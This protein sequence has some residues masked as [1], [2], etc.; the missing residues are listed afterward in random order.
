[1]EDLPYLVSTYFKVLTQ[2]QIMKKKNRRPRNS[3]IP[4]QRLDVDQ[5]GA[6][7]DCGNMD[8]SM[9]SAWRIGIQMLWFG[10][11]LFPKGSHAKAWSLA[12]GTV[13]GRW[14]KFEEMWLSGGSWSLRDALEC[15]WD[16]QVCMYLSLSLSL[17]LL[18]GHHEV[19]H[20]PLSCTP[21][22]MMY[23]AAT[24]P[25]QPDQNKPFLLLRCSSQT[26]VTATE[27]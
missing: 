19:N 4:D 18:L 14:W 10:Q 17:S 8:I 24:G 3:F 16:A 21:A 11:G 26:F 27:N 6:A 12:C 1:M 2:M 22:T 7:D 25:N 23:Y 13:L 20:L 5:G 9:N 15:L